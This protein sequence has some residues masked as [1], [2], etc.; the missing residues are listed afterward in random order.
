MRFIFLGSLFS[1]VGRGNKLGLIVIGAIGSV[2]GVTVE[3]SDVSDEVKGAVKA[4]VD[5]CK[6]AAVTV[7]I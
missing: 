7:A 2:K 5:G 6:G 1:K 4:S 3:L